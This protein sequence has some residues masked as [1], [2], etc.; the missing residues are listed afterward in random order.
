[1]GKQEKQ[2]RRRLSGALNAA[3]SLVL[4]AG[5]LPALPAAAAADDAAGVGAAD[6]GSVH[7]TVENTTC[8]APDA[9]WTGTLVDTDVALSADS[10]MMNCIKA[11]IEGAGK[12]QVGADRRYISE[13]EGL[14]EHDGDDHDPEGKGYSG[15][16]GTL[17]DWFTNEGFANYTV[18]NGKLSAG[19]E[20]R[21]MYTCTMYDLGNP[22]N[23]DRTLAGA[24]FSAGALDKE[25][26]PSE[27][28]YTLTVPEGTTS[29][30]VTPTA[31]NKNYQ[32]R[33]FARGVQYKRS[34]QVPVSDGTVITVKSGY[35]S[36]DDAGDSA[37][38]VAYTF[39]VKVGG[40][41][42]EPG[43]KV[44]GSGEL[45]NATWTVYDNGV[46]KLGKIDGTDGKMKDAG[47]G[48][49]STYSKEYGST[50][51][52]I[53]IDEGITYLGD[54]VLN[55]LSSATSITFPAS[56]ADMGTNALYGCDNVTEYRCAEGGSIVVDGNYL[57]KDGGAT[58]LKII[59]PTLVT[60]AVTLP[61]TVT[62]IGD[63]FRGMTAMTSIELPAGLTSMGQYAFSGCTGLTEITVPCNLPSDN[64]SAFDGCANLTAIT[65]AEG[66]TSVLGGGMGYLKGLTTINFPSTLTELDGSVISDSVTTIT[67][68]EGCAFGLEDGCIV[69]TTDAG[70][71]IAKALS[72]AAIVDGNGKLAIPEGVI[73]IGASAYAQRSDIKS[74][75]F[76]STLKTIGSAAFANCMNLGGELAIPQGV[77]ELGGSAFCNTAIT[78]AVIPSGVTTIGGQLFDYCESLKE[79][80][81][82]SNV[83]SSI[84]NECSA[85][86]TITVTEGAT[87]I[88]G[89]A[90]AALKKKSHSALTT[91][92]LPTSLQTLEASAL[93]NN[94]ALKNIN[95]AEGGSFA[96]ADGLLTKPADHV[97]VYASPSVKG[98]FA[99]PEETTEIAACAF[100]NCTGITALTLPEGLKTIGERAFQNEKKLTGELT[101]PSTVTSIGAF[102]FAGCTGLTKVNCLDPA[103]PADI[104]YGA[105]AFGSCTGVTEVH[106]P[107]GLTTYDG[108]F[109]RVKKVTALDIPETVTSLGD[110]GQNFRDMTALRSVSAPGVAA[111]RGMEF[112]SC[113]NLETLDL[114]GATSISETAFDGIGDKLK[115]LYLGK[116]LASFGNSSMTYPT[117]IYYSG[118]SED[119]GKIEFGDKVAEGIERCGTT[120]VYNYKAASEPLSVIS[121]PADISA[122]KG[123]KSEPATFEVAVPEGATAYYF[124][125]GADG[126]CVSAGT[127]ASFTTTTSELGSFEYR[128]VAKAIAADGTVSTAASEPFTLTVSE[129][130]DIFE[131]SGTEEDPYLL[132]TAQDLVNLSSMVNG[133][134]PYENMVFKMAADIELPAGWTPIGATKDGSEDIR[135]GKNLNAFKGTFDGAGHL[136]TVP[137][138]GKPLFNYVWGATIK[139]LEVY[140]ERIEGYGL[141]DK[142]SGVGLSGTGV[143]ITGVTLKT[144]TSTL[145]SGF[146]GGEATTNVYAG[147]SAGFTASISDCTIDEGVTVGYDGTQDMIGA[148]AGRFQGTIENCASHATVKGANYVGGIIG[149]RDNALGTCAVIGCT[150]DG[151]VQASGKNAGG[152]VGGGYENSTAPNGIHATVNGCVSSGAISGAENVGGILGGDEYIA[153]AWNAYEFKDN[154]FSGTVSG[155][156]NVGAIIG[157][158]DSL[159]KWDDISGNTFTHGCGAEKGIGKVWIVDTS[160]AA[161]TAVEGVVYVNTETSVAGCPQVAGCAWKTAHNRTDD[162]L[163]AD[164]DAL[165]R[166]LTYF[167]VSTAVAAGDGAAA[168]ASVRAGDTV[169]VNV[170]VEANDG[171]AALSGT[172]DYDPAVFELVGVER[173]AG[174]SEGASFLPG[175]GAAEAAFSFYGNDA[176]ADAKGGIVVATA[177]FRAVAAADGATIGVKGATAAISGD[178]LDHGATAGAVV[179]LDV[180]ADAALGDA[181][182]SGRVNIVDAQVVYDMAAGAY[183]EGYAALPLPAGWTRATLL[184]AANVNGDDAVDAADAFAIQRFVHRGSWS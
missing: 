98:A 79:L 166:E 181:N 95:C 101:I 5:L 65:F 77:T 43:A 16:M 39:T 175:G 20:I 97:L 34:A 153:Q 102:A 86:E 9:A 165:C 147:V 172:L 90:F 142:W 169:T 12:T 117:L 59:D 157:Y 29:V 145:K 41:A 70:K 99:V 149:T 85:L 152:I 44:L 125:Y 154:A 139:N 96:Y 73:S 52:S 105:R 171:V 3:L 177:T 22:N 94:T 92:N 126:E 170:S 21:V 56:L 167:E 108:L 151:A 116:Q 104:T 112:D 123:L 129:V 88:T 180:L 55:G 140:G 128:C 42:P 114:S 110:D 136:L 8:P 48:E 131:G 89:D 158:Y 156:A 58:L 17:N 64:Y 113:P 49:E 66:V 143:T 124:W 161:P 183:G 141:I 184:W 19:D 7:V 107:Q 164:A 130:G 111:V 176:A 84:C 174:L 80:V 6:L 13:I 11:A 30:A 62:A 61:A 133:G 146:L 118:S 150:F 57:L 132:K 115:E 144:G 72:S 75:A 46:L 36:M 91:L 162:P 54:Y 27:H 47:E 45:N 63:Q 50:I 23:I 51:T 1:M 109:Y 155:Q 81:V 37:D 160:C 137:A 26:S 60:G 38:A 122:Y 78:K 103:A 168:P 135:R 18:A 32:V 33:T 119:W 25:F 173:G 163:G 127:S 24:A 148:F 87:A 28:A 68:A 35:A 182:G 179:S 69:K 10:T 67:F 31:A 71:E 121:Q 74:V 83:E 15:W 14:A 82:G 138:G 134:E 120:V 4:A 178:A 53:V 100:V 159:N 2:R 40:D 76:P 93:K 106:L